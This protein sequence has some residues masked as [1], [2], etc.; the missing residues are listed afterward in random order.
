MPDDLQPKDQNERIA[1]FRAQMVGALVCRDLKRGELA[2]LLRELSMQRVRPPGSD[3]TRTFAVPT[4]KRWYQRYRKYGLDGLRPVSRKRGFGCNLPDDKR[5][6][7]LDIRRQN[8]HASVTVML[9]TLIAQGQLTSGDVS[10]GTVRRLLVANGL[11]RQTLRQSSGGKNR[12]ARWEAE[13]PGALWHADVCHGPAMHIDGRN[14]PLRIHAILDDASRFIVAIQACDN[15][16]EIE[17]LMLLVKA[18]RCAGPPKILYLDNGSTYSGDALAAACALLG[19]TLIHAQPYDPQARG[20]M[21]RFWRT[22]RE[23]CLDHI[24]HAGNLHDVQVRLLAFLDGHY[25]HAA[26]A[27]LLGE[28]PQR[29]WQTVAHAD[30]TTELVG[31]QKL[32]AALTVRGRRRIKRDGTLMVGGVVWEAE[33]GFLAGRNVTVARTLLEPNHAPRVEHDGKTYTL[34]AVDV[35]ANAKRRR[36]K[37]AKPTP[38]IDAVLFDPAGALLRKVLHR[39]GEENER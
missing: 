28:S 1:I 31:E 18:L 19:I 11:D 9:R 27:G 29:R 14:V 21:E 6:L 32:R 39:K 8:P 4:L 15:E 23:G 12:R 16:R 24:G 22:L 5:K 10:A 3:V 25:H 30:G 2:A 17:M 37:T 35:V 33:Q 34:R 26:H 7:I 13:S 20:K 36:R 38:G